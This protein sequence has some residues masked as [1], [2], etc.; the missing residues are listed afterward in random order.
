VTSKLQP[1]RFQQDFSKCGNEF[2]DKF[3]RDAQLKARNY[4]EFLE[5]IPYN[6]LKNMQYLDKNGFSIIY[7]AVWLIVKSSRRY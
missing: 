7:K 6:R 5:W 3:I 4:Y 2:I 1:K